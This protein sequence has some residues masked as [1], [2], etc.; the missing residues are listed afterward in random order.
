MI[1]L[2]LSDEQRDIVEGAATLLAEYAPVARLRPSAAPVDV[3]RLLA[4]WGWF[5]IGVAEAA[6][7]LGLGLAEEALLYGLGG[8]F[9]LSPQV[10]ATTLAVP[11]VDGELRAR[12]LDGRDRAAVA[13]AAG[14]SDRGDR[15]DNVYAFDLD[16]AAV[17]VLVAGDRVELYPAEAFGG[18]IV[19]G[20]DETV[21]LHAGRLDATRRLAATDGERA[22]LLVAAMLA[23]IAK[24]T[25]ALAV[26]HATTREQFGQP[27]G[28]FQAVKHRC[29]DMAVA[30]FSAEAQVLMAAVSAADGGLLPNTA[31]AA[32]QITAAAHVATRAARA[33]AAAAVQVH[34]GMGFTAECDAHLFLKRAH[35][36]TRLIG[37][38]GEQDPRL[39][40]YAA[41]EG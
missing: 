6:G 31:D 33:N 17:V 25:T 12:L 9:L 1:E 37:G 23:G 15:C 4:E 29:A 40:A 28:A 38:L 24:A 35:V 41:N 14:A 20:L 26:A 39:L 18:E 10:L 2:G 19:A 3:H 5:G 32:F 16:G 27:I 7:G 8:E 34:G 22:M 11:L 30:A 36:L 21:T 13:V